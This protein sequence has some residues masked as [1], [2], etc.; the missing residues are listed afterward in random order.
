MRRAAAAGGAV[1]VVAV[2]IGG[3][4]PGNDGP[5]PA[6]AADA[7]PLVVRALG[8]RPEDSAATARVARTV[9]RE[10]P[11]VR[12][13]LLRSEGVADFGQNRFRGRQTLGDEPAVEVFVAGRFQFER[14]PGGAWDKAPRKGREVDDPVPSVLL[15]RRR[16]SGA[17]GHLPSEDDRRAIVDALLVEVVAGGTSRQHGA[18]TRRY[19][20]ALDRDRA[21]RQLDPPLAEELSAWTFVPE[22]TLDA[23]LWIDADGR[24]RKLSWPFLTSPDAPGALRIEEEWWDFGGPGPVALP[25]DLGDPTATGGEGRTSLTI[26]G[27]TVDRLELVD[28]EDGS[29]IDDL[30]SDDYTVNVTERDGGDRRYFWAL[31]FDIPQ[32]GVRPPAT[33]PARVTRTTSQAAGTRIVDEHVVPCARPEVMATVRELV[34]DSDDR[35]VRFRATFRLACSSGPPAEG[36]LRFHSLT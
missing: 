20:I 24:V 30:Q 10:G 22:K 9:V 1:A 18:V 4:S 7:R 2:L 28:G 11:G 3:C 31:A 19:R 17:A 26:T 5:P 23:H 34:R 36:D 12:E 32:E 25:D 33:V 35:I 6:D 15:G 29:S 13:V 14:P 8:W 21:T 27:G 16:D